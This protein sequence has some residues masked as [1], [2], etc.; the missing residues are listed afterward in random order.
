MSVETIA[1][2]LYDH[3]NSRF[4]KYVQ[5]GGESLLGVASKLR[6]VAGTIIN[7][8]TEDTLSSAD[9]WLAL[10][11]T[12]LDAIKDTAGI[13]KITDA[14]PTGDN[15]I[16]R[17][18]VGDGSNIAALQSI[19]GVQHLAAGKAN[20]IDAANSTV[21]QLGVAGEVSCIHADAG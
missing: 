11:D 10:I 13:K 3:V 7:P 16:G 8:A 14:L 19:D 4:L 1:R 18:K 21:A 5:E 17:T 9:A 2:V 15:W 12:T 6:N 20:I